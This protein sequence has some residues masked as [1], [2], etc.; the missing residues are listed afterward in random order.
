MPHKSSKHLSVSEL[1][2]LHETHIVQRQQEKPPNSG[3]T[4]QSSGCFISVLLSALSR[5]A[6]ILTI[7]YVNLIIFYE[8]ESYLTLINFAF[9]FAILIDMI[10]YLKTRNDYLRWVFLYFFVL[11][12]FYF[13]SGN[14]CKPFILFYTLSMIPA[15]WIQHEVVRSIIQKYSLKN[16]SVFKRFLMNK[17]LAFDY[18]RLFLIQS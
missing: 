14:S 12:T 15:L 6:C 13:F 17:L 1:V 5:L 10:R 9:C 8:T 4:V 16:S 11:F 2:S 7:S 3:H 18:F